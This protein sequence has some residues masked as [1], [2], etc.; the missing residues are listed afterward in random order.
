M[1][2]YSSDTPLVVNKASRLVAF[3]FAIATT[4]VVVLVP[5]PKIYSKLVL[6]RSIVASITLPWLMAIQASRL[7]A[8]SDM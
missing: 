7:A 5:L 1:Y 3:F 8:D 6:T 4:L 2:L